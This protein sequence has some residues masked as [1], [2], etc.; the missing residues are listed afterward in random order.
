M[1]VC[2]QLGL[3]CLESFFNFT[4]FY[5][6]LST[7]FHILEKC[8]K[9]VCNLHTIWVTALWSWAAYWQLFFHLERKV[10]AS[11]FY[12]RA[13]N[14]HIALAESGFIAFL[15]RWTKLFQTMPVTWKVKLDPNT[16]SSVDYGS[17]SFS[18]W[19]EINLMTLTFGISVNYTTTL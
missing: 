11:A 4:T 2:L 3:H 6:T 17:A 5:Q 16:R 10:I 14:P 9:C 18:C 19:F 1:N 8:D 12:I 13:A 7:N 15:P